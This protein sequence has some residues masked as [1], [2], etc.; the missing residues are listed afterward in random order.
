MAKQHMTVRLISWRSAV[1]STGFKMHCPNTYYKLLNQMVIYEKLENTW[2]AIC[3]N[4][5]LTFTIIT[6]ASTKFVFNSIVYVFT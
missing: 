3:Q 4:C 5:Q 1:Q 6:F 2:V